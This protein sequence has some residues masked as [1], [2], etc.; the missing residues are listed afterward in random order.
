MYEF[1]DR[2]VT[3]LDRSGSFLVWSMRSWVKS[4]GQRGCPVTAIAP[5]FSRWNVIAGLQPFLRIMTLLNRHG[6]ETFQFC[7]PECNHV[8]EH[9]AIL[10]RLTCDLHDGQAQ[11]VRDTLALLIEEEAIGDILAAFSDLGQALH[12]GGIAPAATPWQPQPAP[13]AATGGGGRD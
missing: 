12:K 5:A 2:P 9:E 8:S 4:M 3:T 13:P 1:L 7:A 11:A 6:L 10:L